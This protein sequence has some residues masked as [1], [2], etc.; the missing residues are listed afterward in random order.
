MPNYLVTEETLGKEQ[1]ADDDHKDRE[2]CGKNPPPTSEKIACHKHGEIIE[3]EDEGL[4]FSEDGSKKCSDENDTD[5]YFLEM[6][7]NELFIT[8]HHLSPIL[9]WSI[10]NLSLLMQISSPVK[11]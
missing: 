1:N 6:F 3:V 11:K 8:F 4:L 2:H 5:K 9:L 7:H 10:L